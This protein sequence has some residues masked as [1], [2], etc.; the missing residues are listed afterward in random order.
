MTTRLQSLIGLRGM[1][2]EHRAEIVRLRKS[3]TVS[4]ERAAK[5]AARI[6]K[7][8]TEFSALAKA[9]DVIRHVNELMD[10]DDERFCPRCESMPALEG[11][12]AACNSKDPAR[13]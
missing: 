12:C 10:I 1:L 6:E 2:L 8:E 3:V 7:L 13:V 11:V 5:N 4:A 9:M